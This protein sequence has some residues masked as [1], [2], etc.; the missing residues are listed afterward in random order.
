V[1]SVE[2]YRDNLLKLR[3]IWLDYGTK[4]EFSHIPVGKSDL[5]RQLAKA[6]IPHL[7]SVRF[8]I[9]RVAFNSPATS[10]ELPWKF[11]EAHE[12]FFPHSPEFGRVSEKTQIRPVV[13]DPHL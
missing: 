8:A 9:A 2:R 10:L 7:R 11:P 1:N 12:Y 6:G 5:S 4:D 3:G 13:Q